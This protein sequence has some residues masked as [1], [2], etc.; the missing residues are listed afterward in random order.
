VN[1]LLQRKGALLSTLIGLT[2][3]FSA[4]TVFRHHSLVTTYPEALRI[5][6]AGDGR[7]DYPWNSPRVEDE[8]GINKTITSEIAEAVLKESAQ[9]LLWT[10]DFTN[11]P[12][13][14]PDT[15]R[16]QLRAW[17][18]II[19]PL[20]DRRV[21]VLPVRGNHEVYRRD[22]GSNDPIPIL[23]AK[24]GWNEVFSG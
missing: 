8:E 5:V 13:N 22:K 21:T 12:D 19:Q 1:R 10:G 17:R 16:K 20:Y 14:N 11:V 3:V 2:V 4:V 7:A 15:F 6:V 9:I 18:E 24:E 23:Y